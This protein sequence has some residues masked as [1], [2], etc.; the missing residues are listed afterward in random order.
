MAI[1]AAMDVRPTTDRGPEQQVGRV[2]YISSAPA[3]AGWARVLWHNGDYATLSAYPGNFKQTL[4]HVDDLQPE[5]SSDE[6]RSIYHL[7]G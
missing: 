1:E 5:R 3:P 2:L 6:G 7:D 4:I